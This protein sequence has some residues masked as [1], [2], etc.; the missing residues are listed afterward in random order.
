M[1]RHFSKFPHFL[2]DKKIFLWD[3][4]LYL[5]LNFAKPIC[6]TFSWIHSNIRF[7]S[8]QRKKNVTF[9]YRFM[10]FFCFVWHQSSQSRT[11]DWWKW[12]TIK[13]IRRRKDLLGIIFC[14]DIYYCI[15]YVYFI[16]KRPIQVRSK[17]KKKCLKKF[18][19]F[20]MKR[21]LFG[22]IAIYL[23]RYMC[24]VLIMKGNR[25]KYAYVWTNPNNINGTYL[26][27]L[28]L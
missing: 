12:I 7:L 5:N 27:L 11:A 4:Y 25:I 6:S 3:L 16:S 24:C 23:L 21:L 17:Y 10:I 9:L 28:F 22:W 2:N 20:T 1:N 8:R 26:K 18:E 14:S 19:T 15:I 13:R